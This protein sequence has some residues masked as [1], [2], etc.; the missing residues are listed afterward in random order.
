MD[1][2]VHASS[3]SGWPVGS[4]EA[5]I[6]ALE[7]MVGSKKSQLIA[8]TLGGELSCFCHAELEA[9]GRGRWLTG[10]IS[11]RNWAWTVVIWAGMGT[12]GL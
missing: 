3:V 8:P 6:Y 5:P 4:R 9:Y 11:C 2:Y 12:S 1:K 10:H 7:Q